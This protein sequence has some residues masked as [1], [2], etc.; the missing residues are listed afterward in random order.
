MSLPQTLEDELTRLASG[1]DRILSH[2]ESVGTPAIEQHGLAV[3]CAIRKYP[4]HREDFGRW[5]VETNAAPT[6]LVAFCMHVLRWPEVRS[7]LEADLKVADA[8]SNWRRIPFLTAVLD[9]FEDS[10]EDAE[11]FPSLRAAAVET[12]PAWPFD[13]APNVA[14]ITTR[15]VLDDGLPILLVQHYE[16]DH[17]WAFL[18]G[19]TSSTEDGRVVGMGTAVSLDPT[20]RTIADL[21]PG[22]W[23][24]RSAVGATWH[25]EQVHEREDAG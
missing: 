20:L 15:G 7:K 12:D 14:A 11:F 22:W 19:T 8:E 24:T 23:A 6:E 17:C 4:E 13:Q 25:R 9:A 2:P 1:A 21:Q 3:L 16:D 18:C 5:L 10:W